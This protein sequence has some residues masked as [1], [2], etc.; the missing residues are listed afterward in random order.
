MNPLLLCR[1]SPFSVGWLRTKCSSVGINSPAKGMYN[2]AG[3]FWWPFSYLISICMEIWKICTSTKYC[4]SAWT[5][6]KTGISIH[7]SVLKWSEYWWLCQAK[8]S[9]VW[10]EEE[11]FFGSLP[12]LSSL[13]ILHPFLYS[14][15]T[16]RKYFN[17]PLGDNFEILKN[18]ISTF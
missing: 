9:A 14:S 16:S 2:Q 8:D 11:S 17:D 10:K 12:F 18:R 4:Y 3:L 7:S 1:S 5:E 15:L 13:W 6:T